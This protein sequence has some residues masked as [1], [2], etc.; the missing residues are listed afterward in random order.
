MVTNNQ[1]LD[2]QDEKPTPESDAETL[3][4][5]ILEE[6]SKLNDNIRITE[7][8]NKQLEDRLTKLET[9]AFQLQNL[10]KNPEFL[11]DI[12]MLALQQLGANPQAIQQQPQQ[13]L[14]GTPQPAATQPTSNDPQAN[15]QRWAELFLQGMA[16]SKSGSGNNTQD[17]LGA[18]IKLVIDMFKGFTELQKVAI[19]GIKEVSKDIKQPQVI[20]KEKPARQKKKTAGHHRLGH[21]PIAVIEETEPESDFEEEE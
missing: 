6:L 11:K 8:R 21:E 5:L 2:N 19:S 9:Y 3:S 15:L 16:I 1:P 20:Y 10:L 18:S 7:Q 14:Q 4:Q 13:P 17:N 12:G